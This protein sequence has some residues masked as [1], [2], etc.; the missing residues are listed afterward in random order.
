MANAITSTGLTT[1]TYAELLAY[2]TNAY[3]TIYGADI[4]LGPDTPDGQMMGIQ[5]QAILDLLDLVTQVYTSFD[6]DQA[7]GVTLDQRV[8]LNGIQRQA[9]TYT[10]TNITIVN[11]Q[12]LNLY[13]LEQSIEPV[14]TVADDSGNQWQLVTSTSIAAGTHVL[15]FQAANAGAVLTTPNTITTPVTVVLGVQTIN[16]PTT[17]TTLGINEETDAELKVRRLKS[18]SLASQGYLTGL[19]AALENISGL[20]SAFVYEN[21][22]DSTDG[23][24]VPSHSIWVIVS[25]GAT[26]DIANAIYKKRNA[27]CGMKGS[28][29]YNVTQADGSLFTVKWD[30]VTTETLYIQFDASS[31]NGIDAPDTAAILAELPDLM[32]MGVY[33]QV[34]INDLATLV[35]QIDNNCLVTNAGFSLSGAGPWTTTLTPSAKNKQFTLVSGDIDIT[36][37]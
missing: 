22:T 20:S 36:V 21:N 31:L 32:L 35:Q 30:N 18:V 24:G 7:I 27:G 2:Y 26:A 13:G 34:N 10:V 28:Q 5:I 12:S 15:V 4:N 19:L 8:A 3:Q 11:N 33:E 1:D 25:G 17:Y 6:P 37:V 29:T 9:G 14:Y 23:D 16:N